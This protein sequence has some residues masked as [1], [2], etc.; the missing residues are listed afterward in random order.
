MS[1]I[2]TTNGR[3]C[4]TPSG[5]VRPCDCEDECCAAYC[6][7]PPSPDGGPFLRRTHTMRFAWFDSEPVFSAGTRFWASST[8]FI[9]GSQIPLYF[10]RLTPT[11]RASA[12]EGNQPLRWELSEYLYGAPNDSPFPSAPGVHL[13]PAPSGDAPRV[14]QPPISDFPNPQSTRSVFFDTESSFN[15]TTGDWYVKSTLRLEDAFVPDNQ[16]A[17]VAVEFRYSAR[18]GSVAWGRLLV[19]T[20][21]GVFEREFAPEDF[22]VGTDAPYSRCRPRVRTPPLETGIGDSAI[23]SGTSLVAFLTIGP[24]I[25]ELVDGAVQVS[26]GGVDDCC[27]SPGVCGVCR[28]DGTPPRYKF[29]AS[30]SIGFNGLPSF[31]DSFSFPAGDADAPASACGGGVTRLLQGGQTVQF[32]RSNADDSSQVNVSIGT[33]SLSP[34]EQYGGNA[35]LQVRLWPDGRATWVLQAGVSRYN[36]FGAPV[37]VRSASYSSNPAPF[38]YVGESYFEYT[39]HSSSSDIDLCANSGTITA[40]V[41]VRGVGGFA[42]ITSHATVTLR[43]EVL[44]KITAPCGVPAAAAGC[45]GCGRTAAEIGAPVI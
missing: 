17:S 42:G 2:Q 43:F 5:R 9:G 33:P 3:F 39:T 38:G 6:R 35:S 15:P 44:N 31:S 10:P 29:D 27:G 20:G 16:R 40:S 23:G 7:F 18:S 37:S 21:Q 41:A 4:L 32:S 30:Y 22:V 36:P 28:D 34:N 13:P 26:T 25:Y 12:C 14:N 11:R 45:A 19:N 8:D 1:R 24:G